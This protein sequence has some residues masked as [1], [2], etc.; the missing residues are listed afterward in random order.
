MSTPHY[1]RQGRYVSPEE[2]DEYR[3]FSNEREAKCMEYLNEIRGK[4][5][6]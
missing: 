6:K 3:E 2:I 1:Y 4:D 5:E